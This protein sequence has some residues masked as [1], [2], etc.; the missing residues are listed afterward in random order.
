MRNVVRAT[1]VALFSLTISISVSLSILGAANA[2]QNA[3]ADQGQAAQPA[4]AAAAPAASARIIVTP[5]ADYSGFDYETVKD[6][7]STPARP[8]APT[9]SPAAPSPSTPRPA[10]ASSRSDFGTLT[11][12][13]A[14][15][16]A[17]SS[18]APEL[19]PS[20]EEQ[21][22]G[23]LDFLPHHFIDEARELAGA[24]KRAIPA[25]QRLLPGAA[26]RRRHRV[27]RRQATTR[28]PT[29]FGQAL[30]LADD[31][32]GLWL[33]FAIAS[34]AR[35]PDNYSDKQAQPG[36]TAPP[37][38]STAIIRSETTANRAQALASS[39]DGFEQ[40]RAVGQAYRAYRASLALVDDADVRA[41]YDKVIAEHGFRIV[42]NTVDADS[43]RSA[44]LHR[45][46]RRR[47]R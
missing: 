31:N 25:G 30:A 42:S 24:I 33:D 45:L 27:S 18:A 21:R 16:P 43:G 38:R 17:A 2:A 20:L 7:T 29:Q 34:L 46:L 40:A 13:P 37:R 36:P 41:T 6:V 15:P 19:T 23:E 8:P 3:P 47:S 28:R 4:P 1:F 10:G 9:I 11:A 14:R 44:H 22:L 39:G 32:P 12:T 26:R 35:N 5:D